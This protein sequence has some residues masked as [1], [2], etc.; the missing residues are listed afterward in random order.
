MQKLNKI[1]VADIS[2]EIICMKVGQET[3]R[4]KRWN[5]IEWRVR[6][7]SRANLEYCTLSQRHCRKV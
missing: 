6:S 3:P 4:T 7:E 2:H 1:N 5:T